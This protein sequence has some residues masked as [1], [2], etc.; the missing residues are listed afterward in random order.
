MK[1]VLVF[2]LTLALVTGCA[3]RFKAGSSYV[4]HLPHDSAAQKIAEDA[5]HRPP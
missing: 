3:N 5:C 1:R 4:G 2:F